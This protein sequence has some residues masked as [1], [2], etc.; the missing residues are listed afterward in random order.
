[1]TTNPRYP[2]W[3]VSKGRSDTMITSRSLN[4]MKVPHR[5][6]IEPQDKLDYE[7]ALINFGL[8]FAKLEIAPFSNHGDGP[9]RARN[10]CWDVSLLEGHKRFWVLDDNIES[11]Y[12][13]TEGKRIRVESGVGFR[14]CEDFVDRYENVPLAGLQYRF[15]IAPGQDYPPFVTNTRIYSAALIECD[16]PIRFRGRYNEDTCISLDVL[17]DGD[18]TVQFNFFLQGKIVTQ[19][20][21]GGNTAEFYHAE[22]DLSKKQDGYNPEGTLNKSQMLVDMH[23]DVARLVWKFGRFHHEVN[24]QPF[25]KNLLRLKPDVDLEALRAKGD[26]NYGLKLITNWT[27][28]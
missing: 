7:K 17:K 5:I 9:G 13:F 24:Y 18:C 10:Y 21:K 15:F 8:T 27:G 2:V 3:I 16:Y 19:A 1:M 12:R 28:P 6:L 26:N 20:L 4:R 22:G 11:F 25:K 14:I 23:P